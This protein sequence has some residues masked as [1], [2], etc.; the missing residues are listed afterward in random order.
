[1]G[2]MIPE[3][4]ASESGLSDRNS[5]FASRDLTSVSGQLIFPP[6]HR[7]CFWPAADQRASPLNVCLERG[8]D[9][10]PRGSLVRFSPKADKPKSAR[11]AVLEDHRRARN[12]SA[13]YARASGTRVSTQ[14][15]RMNIVN[16]NTTAAVTKVIAAAAAKAA[17]PDTTIRA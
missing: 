5:Q 15:M 11:D 2:T 14:P 17:R 13:R 3:M 12:L 1:M 8:A 10:Q 7:D 6:K 4:A 9:A 16:P